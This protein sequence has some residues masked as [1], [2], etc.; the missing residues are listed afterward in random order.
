MTDPEKPGTPAPSSAGVA[1]LEIGRYD[2]PK[3]SW[4]IRVRLEDGR[5][6]TAVCSTTTLLQPGRLARVL[7]KESGVPAFLPNPSEWRQLIRNVRVQ[8]LGVPSRSTL[9]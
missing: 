7:S 6:M 2:S 5:V 9:S 8:I 3:P 4:R 1:I